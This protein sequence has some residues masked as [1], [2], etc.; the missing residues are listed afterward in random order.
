MDNLINRIC[1]HCHGEFN[2][3]LEDNEDLNEGD[4]KFC[5]L[6]GEELDKDADLDFDSLTIGDGDLFVD[7]DL[8]EED[9]E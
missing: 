2:I 4:I 8:L 5:I 7:G 1:G 9:Y 6:C 3:N